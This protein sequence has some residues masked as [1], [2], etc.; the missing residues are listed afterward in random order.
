MDRV[1]RPVAASNANALLDCRILV[2]SRSQVWQNVV[3]CV[4]VGILE[5]VLRTS[6]SSGAGR[7][8]HGLPRCFYDSR[9]SGV[10]HS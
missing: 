4:F 2:F 3:D 6:Q 7:A 1:P 10:E 9:P 5:R 8:R